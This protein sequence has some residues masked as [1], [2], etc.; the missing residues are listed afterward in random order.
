MENTRSHYA[1][2]IELKGV[3]EAGWLPAYFPRSAT[4]IQ[5]G[6]NIDTNRVWA[7]FSYDAQ[8]IPSLREI[9]KVLAENESG[10]K[11]L[12]PPFDKRTSTFVLKANGK[13]YY[14]SYENGI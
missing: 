9:C 4:D 1:S 11:F 5:E 6:H 14:L 8:D 7:S 2:Y 13:G 3:I 12:C 10:L